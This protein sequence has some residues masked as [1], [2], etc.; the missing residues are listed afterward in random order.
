MTEKN[1]KV[2]IVPVLHKG[3]TQHVWDAKQKKALDKALMGMKEPSSQAEVLMTPM[4]RAY[5][6]QLDA[7]VEQKKTTVTVLGFPND[8]RNGNKNKQ[9]EARAAVKPSASV[10]RKQ[11]QQTS[12]CVLCYRRRHGWV[13][14]SHV[15]PAV[16]LMQTAMTD[17]S[18]HPAGIE[19]SY[20]LSGS[21]RQL[22]LS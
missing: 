9:L 13:H 20:C 8:W 15:I 19:M 16:L 5:R 17:D 22:M 4:H 21:G 2:S 14:N 11:G 18:C 7:T 6:R 3:K 10:K 12:M 1:L